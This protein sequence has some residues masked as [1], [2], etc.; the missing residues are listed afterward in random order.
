MNTDPI[1]VACDQCGARP[2]SSCRTL[3]R[4][5]YTKAHLARRYDAWGADLVREASAMPGGTLLG[6]AWLEVRS[7]GTI[8]QY[9]FLEA[10]KWMQ[11]RDR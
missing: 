5:K 10:V 6:D 1:T 9:A 7:A 11:E 3:D 4:T 2:G 8:R